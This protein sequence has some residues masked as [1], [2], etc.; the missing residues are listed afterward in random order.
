M[1]AGTRSVRGPGSLFGA[2]QAIRRELRDEVRR[3]KKDL[4][5][6]TEAERRK[7]AQRLSMRLTSLEIYPVLNLAARD[8][9]MVIGSNGLL[10]PVRRRRSRRL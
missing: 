6:M 4:P 3:T 9:Q 8:G 10:Q 2:G 5:Q 7:A 1:R